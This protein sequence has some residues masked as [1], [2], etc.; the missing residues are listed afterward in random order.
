ME[1]AWIFKREFA[2]YEKKAKNNKPFAMNTNIRE[3]LDKWDNDVE[4][5]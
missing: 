4:V 2:L 3:R 5:M 1:K